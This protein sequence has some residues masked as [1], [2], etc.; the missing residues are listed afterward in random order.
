MI[1]RGHLTIVLVAM[2][3]VAGLAPLTEAGDE[4]ATP[5]QAERALDLVVI[6]KETKEP[7]PGVEL[8]IR[9]V[10]QR[11]KDKTDKDGRCKIV[12]G[13]KEP[14]YLRI[15]VAKEGFVPMR[16]AWSQGIGRPKIP[17]Q[18]TLALERGTSIGGI[19]QDEQ[20]KPIEGVSVYLLVASGDE[21]ERVAIWDHAEKTDADGH[22][23]CDI[24]PA[25]L[26]DIAIR[27][28]HPDYISDAM[29]GMTPRPTIEKLRA[30]TGVMVM[31]QGLNVTGRV[32][33]VNDRPIEGASVA[34]GSDRFGSNYPSTKTDSEGRFEFGNAKQD[35]MVLTVQAQGYAPDLKHVTIYKPMKPIE[36][37][38]E[39]GHT[40]R[41]R[42]VDTRGNPV[43]GV[44]VSAN[45]WRGHRSLDWRVDTDAEGRFQWNDAPAD[46]VLFDMS[47]K[48]HMSVRGFAMSPSEQEYE[49]TMPTQLK[50]SG[51]VVDAETGEPVADFKVLSGIDRG[52]GRPV[53]WQRRT[54]RKFTEGHYET[55]FTY[56]R[57]RRGS[58]ICAMAGLLRAPR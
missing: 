37:R 45:A 33:D 22:W 4:T 7:I 13:E 3:V 17:S 35:E 50:I 1:G 51:T 49:I 47:K 46:A 53:S 12:L 28:A 2:T 58:F 24:V 43:A 27:L 11:R 40:L 23:R 21:V 32:C 5:A 26:D 10:R 42:I 6:N 36:F 38:L 15:E 55:S 54:A 14:Q 34:Q 16:L 48:G 25:K 8:S 39:P 52:E 30:M 20:G 44:F 57:D 19:V 56:P 31:K 9:I 41:G 18:Y 29:Y